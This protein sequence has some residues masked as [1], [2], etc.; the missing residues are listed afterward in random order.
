[1]RQGIAHAKQSIK[2][3]KQ[4]AVHIAMAIFQPLF[5]TKAATPYVE[6][7]LPTYVQEFKI[8]ET[9]ETLPVEIKYLGTND[10]SIKFIPC[11]QPVTVAMAKTDNTALFPETKR[12]KK[13]QTHARANITPAQV[14]GFLNAFLCK[15]VVTK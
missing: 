14:I 6:I 13:E 8:P 10:M 2:P 15:R 7:A 3:I 12:S 4:T 5:S 9:V 1:M 11:I